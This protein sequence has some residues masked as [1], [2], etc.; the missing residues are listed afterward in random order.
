MR[1]WFSPQVMRLHA[2]AVMFAATALVAAT[3]GNTDLAFPGALGWAAH[4]PGGRDGK[5]LRVTTLAA[6]GPGSF[7]EA[8]NTPGPRIIV[9]EVG[10]VIDLD[11]QTLRIKQPFLTIAGQTAPSPGITFIRGGMLIDT[12]DVVVRHVRVRPG[13]AGHPKK[14]GW[15]VDGLSTLQG[16]RN[17]IVDHCSFTWAVDENLSVSGKFFVGNSVAEWQRDASQ[18][19]TFSH[20]IIAEGLNQSTHKKGAHSKGTLLMDNSSEVLVY[21]NLYA[22]NVERNPQIKGGTFAAVINNFIYNPQSTAIHYHMTDIWRGREIVIAKNEI[23]GNVLRHGPN[24]PPALALFRFGGLGDLELHAAD[25]LAFDRAGAPA[26]VIF[27]DTRYGGRLRRRD[28]PIYWPP[29]VTALPASQVQEYVCRQAGARPWER[30]A[31]DARIVREAGDGTGR[32]IDS[33]RDVGG[34]P[35][36]GE[37]REPFNPAAWDLRTMT[38][39]T[40]RSAGTIG[41]T[42]W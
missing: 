4:T 16:A 35:V 41:S 21:G 28:Q 42:P 31:I 14:S 40:A 38:R 19:V 25:N 18:R 23:V 8:V 32:V 39:R 10:G 20:N 6:G 26:K 13:E 24:T 22:N 12:H 36:V 17:I 5:I 1:P 11:Q 34:Y 15:E 37:T 30:D 2:V 33:E 9:F 29:G 7:A 3:A 27:E